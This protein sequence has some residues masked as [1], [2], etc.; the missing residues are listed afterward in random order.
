MRI[1]WSKGVWHIWSDDK[2]KIGDADEI[3]ILTNCALRQV[4]NGR[5]GH[6]F[7]DGSLH[8]NGRKAI[9][10]PASLVSEEGANNG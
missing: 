7:V 5:F 10:T 6:L 2:Q 3:R 4:D 9:I 8:W 1:S